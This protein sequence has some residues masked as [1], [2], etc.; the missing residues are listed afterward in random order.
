M[1]AIHFTLL[2]GT[3][4]FNW[5]LRSR[6]RNQPLDWDHGVYGYL[7]YWY[8]KK[9]KNIIPVDGKSDSLISWG[10]PGLTYLMWVMVKLCGTNPRKIRDF[11]SVYYL[12]NTLG[13]FWLGYVAFSVEV[14]LVAA[15]IYAFY[16][17]VPFTWTADQ[18]P[19]NYQTLFITLSTGAFI[20]YIGTG[21]DIWLVFSGVAAFLTMLLKQNSLPYFAGFGFLQL[22]ILND[23]TGFMLF[24][25]SVTIPYLLLF[26]FYMTKG[27]SLKYLFGT[28][29]IY[30][31]L[32]AISYIM[33]LTL[34]NGNWVTEK[35]ELSKFAQLKINVSA[36]MKESS[37]LWL[38][39]LLGLTQI[40]FNAPGYMNIIFFSLFSG[41]IL[42]YLLPRK[43]FPYYFIPFTPVLAITASYW[44]VEYATF[45]FGT[46]DGYVT[47]TASMALSALAA[48]SISPLY[49]YFFRS[50]PAEQALYQYKH[51]MP[52]FLASE[53]IAEHIR[54]NTSPEDTIFVW[55]HNPEIYFLSERRSAVGHL[56]FT[57]EMTRTIMDMNL[58]EMFLK[59]MD[60]LVLNE[61]K[62]IVMVT[63]G[64][65][66]EYIKKLTGLD[67]ETDRSFDTRLGVDD[68]LVYVTYKLNSFSYVP[69]LSKMGEKD[70]N[71]GNNSRALEIF[72][73]L[74]KIEPSNAEHKVSLA[75][76]LWAEDEKEKARDQIDQALELD[77]VNKDAIISFAEMAQDESD[78]IMVISYIENYLSAERYDT[79]IEG[80]LSDFR[81]QL[82]V[83]IV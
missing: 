82:K 31:S 33:N 24:S 50:T 25:G 73:K 53:E 59:M 5:W 22:F 57:S 26:G 52:N 68:S 46:A 74:V 34:E 42:G 2:A 27:F 9:G 38:A 37:P 15:G 19:E 56:L 28:F 71:T 61:A 12:L 30:P 32:H 69:A 44:F 14:G 78:K 51:S 75:T 16:S 3:L 77:P 65:S 21:S 1:Q 43:F 39:G 80:Y 62:Y 81:T 35:E 54:E 72:N 49:A 18:N 67:Y 13:V 47:A 23:Y 7:N 83:E 40:G 10:K 36:Y 48:L 8:Q 11:D 29:L 41:M 4:I 79:E 58:D 66:T 6:F 60:D 70:F 64:I 45:N 17:S 55:N 76:V 63:G 20:Q